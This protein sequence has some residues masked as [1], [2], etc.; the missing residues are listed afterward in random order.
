MT[1]TFNLFQGLQPFLKKGSFLEIGTG[2]GFIA[3]EA[4]FAGCDTV[5]GTDVYNQAV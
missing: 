1:G 4:A 3:L 2:T 5:V